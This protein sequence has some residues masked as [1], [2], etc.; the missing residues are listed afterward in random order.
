MCPRRQKKQTVLVICG[1]DEVNK[2]EIL[3]GLDNNLYYKVISEFS[4]ALQTISDIENGLKTGRNVAITVRADDEDGILEVKGNIKDVV[5]RYNADV[6]VV[7][8][9]LTGRTL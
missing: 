6:I 7:T 8:N 3:N 1:E 2:Q 4:V 9:A 5:T